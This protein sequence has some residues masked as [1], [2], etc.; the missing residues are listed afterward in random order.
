M[1][2]SSFVPQL[3]MSLTPATAEHTGWR[4]LTAPHPNV[5]Y[6]IYGKKMS[7]HT[8]HYI[9]C[10]HELSIIVCITSYRDVAT[11]CALRDKLRA[12]GKPQ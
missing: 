7:E 12:G 1:Q 11:F 5:T 6:L 8:T 3:G 10:E 2:P 9:V 4:L